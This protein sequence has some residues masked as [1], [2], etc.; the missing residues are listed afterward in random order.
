MQLCLPLIGIALWQRW[1]K[2]AIALVVLAAINYSF[3][4][5]LYFGK[6][7]VPATKPARAM[8]MNIYAGNGNTEQVL[9][10]IRTADPDLLLLE[11]VTPKWEQELKVLKKTYT[12]RISKPQDD[13]FGIM[14]LSKV[15]LER[16]K[17]IEIGTAGVP[18]IIAEAHFPMGVIS[19]IGTHPL[20]PM[21][22]IYSSHRNNQLEALP[23]QVQKQ[24]YPVL[25]IGDLNT[26]PWSPYF[27]NLIEASGLKNSMKGFGF[28]P[29]WTGNAFLKIPLDH[30]LHSEEIIIHNRMIGPAVGS[31]HRP[32]IVDFSL[33][34]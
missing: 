28:Q 16:D 11:E 20:P 33:T 31:D 1:N 17:I 6:P 15:P 34:K 21:G 29:S 25:L 26:T 10:A 32:V 19:V 14:L 9:E 23:L 12:Y 3:V 22:S 18:S 4:L 2:R 30:I 13:C 7:E 8:L 5:P 27:K 24:Q